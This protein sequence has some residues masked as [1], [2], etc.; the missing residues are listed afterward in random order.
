MNINQFV[1]KYI[2]IDAE[3]AN[4]PHYEGS[5]TELYNL[6]KAGKVTSV[7][8]NSGEVVGIYVNAGM[9]NIMLEEVAGQNFQSAYCC[10]PVMKWYEI[11]ITAK[12][13]GKEITEIS[14]DLG[15][16]KVGDEV[17]TFSEGNVVTKKTAVSEEL[18]TEVEISA[19]D[20]GG[21]DIATY[22]RDTYDHYLS[23]NS[24][25]KFEYSYDEDD[26]VIRVTGINWGRKR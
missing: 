13:T 6:V 10:K 23:G 22:L 18:P 11:I 3:R 14:E 8:N 4:A 20:I 25:S 1:P 16:C 9:S 21:K 19:D 15:T 26:D 2:N 24:E 17:V 5:F 7:T 12:Y